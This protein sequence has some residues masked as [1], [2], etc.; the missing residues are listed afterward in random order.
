MLKHINELLAILGRM[1]ARGSGH[2]LNR[3]ISCI[4]ELQGRQEM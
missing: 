2:V 3:L 4:V 1:C